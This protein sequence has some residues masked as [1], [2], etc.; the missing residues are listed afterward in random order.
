LLSKHLNYSH[1]LHSLQFER[2]FGVFSGDIFH[3]PSGFV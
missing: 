2:R 3:N 1:H